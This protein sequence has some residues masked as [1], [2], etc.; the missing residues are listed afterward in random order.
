MPVDKFFPLTVEEAAKTQNCGWA[1]VSKH[2][3]RLITTSFEIGSIDFS[4]KNSMRFVVNDVVYEAVSQYYNI[5]GMETTRIVVGAPIISER[6]NPDLCKPETHKYL[7][8]SYL[9]FPK[10][11]AESPTPSESK[12]PEPDTPTDETEGTPPGSDVTG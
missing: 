9:D 3:D 8:P 11:K 10:K 4:L 7:K 6:E 12:T 5:Q 2:K 1:F